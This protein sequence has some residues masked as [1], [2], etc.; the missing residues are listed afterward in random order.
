MRE[1][2]F[3]AQETVRLT[4]NLDDIEFEREFFLENPLFE[5]ISN[6]DNEITYPETPGVV[7]NILWAGNTVSLRGVPTD[8]I[9]GVF[10]HLQTGDRVLLK[11]IKIDEN[12]I[13]TLFFFE[14]D[15]LEQAEVLVDQLFLKRYPMEEEL[16]CNISDPGFSWWYLRTDCGFR[17]NFKSHKTENGSHRLKLG[18]IGDVMVASV[19][20]AKIIEH[21][22]EFMPIQEVKISEKSFV[23]ES[24]EVI[25]PIIEEFKAIFES[26]LIEEDSAMLCE[27]PMTEK[28]FLLELAAIRRFWLNLEKTV[29]P[30]TQAKEKILN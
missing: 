22:K 18:P 26:G 8:N 14:C 9:R 24:S 15:H 23:L 13:D 20:L 1:F 2:D 21:I 7:Y 16:V 25:H 3:L 12:Q 29:S 27:L 6:T 11:K 19:R 4:E 28:L 17:V 5:E 10:D 30:V